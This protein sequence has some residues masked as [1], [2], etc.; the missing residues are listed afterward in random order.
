MEYSFFYDEQRVLLTLKQRSY[1]SME[2]FV[3]YEQDYLAQHD[4]IR[5]RHRNYRV[6]ADCVDYPVQSI[7]VGEAFAALFSKLMSENKGRYAI[8]VSS[9][10]NRIQAQRLI[11]QPNV[12]VFT[13]GKAAMDWLFEP[14]S[15]P[16]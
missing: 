9:A 11:P 2:T 4:R 16:G 3:R 7:E 10:L 14:G 13:E 15:L 5:T 6:F 8:I 12:K 1:W